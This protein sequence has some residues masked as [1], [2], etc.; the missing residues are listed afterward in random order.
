[1]MGV[2]V[3]AFVFVDGSKFP[4]LSLFS[5]CGKPWYKKYETF[6]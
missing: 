6:R 2:C 1:M 4:S 5:F 3:R